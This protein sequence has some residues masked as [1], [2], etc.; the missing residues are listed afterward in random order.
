MFQ[1]RTFL[2]GAFTDGV[3]YGNFYSIDDLRGGFSSAL[4]DSEWQRM[5]ME[6]ERFGTTRL[7]P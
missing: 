2:P 4:P 7:A 5:K 3:T 6:L 1:V